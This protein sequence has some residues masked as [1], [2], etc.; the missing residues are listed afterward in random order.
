MHSV[1]R[2]PPPPPPPCPALRSPRR[3]EEQSRELREEKAGSCGRLSTSDE[4]LSRRPG[5]PWHKD[6]LVLVSFLHPRPEGSATAPWK[7]AAVL[8]HYDAIE[9]RPFLFPSLGSTDCVCFSTVGTNDVETSALHIIVGRSLPAGTDCGGGSGPGL[10]CGL[11]RASRLR[12]SVWAV[13]PGSDPS[14]VP[15]PQ[16]QA[17]C[18]LAAA[19]VSPCAPRLTP[20][21]SMPQVCPTSCSLLLCLG[22]GPCPVG[23][24]LPSPNPHA[25]DALSTW[26]IPG[27]CVLGPGAGAVCATGRRPRSTWLSPRP[28]R[29]S[30]ETRS[31]ASAAGQW[32]VDNRPFQSRATP[33]FRSRNALPGAR[34]DVFPNLFWKCP[35]NYVV[36]VTRGRPVPPGCTPSPRVLVVRLGTRSPGPVRGWRGVAPEWGPLPSAGDSLSMDVSSVHHNGALLRYSVSLLGYGFYGDIIKD[37][38]KKRWMGLVR[39]DFSGE[40]V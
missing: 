33:P 7:P 5:L 1:E 14:G 17:P 4:F 23:T 19:S 16:S 9:D 25:C 40:A 37:S 36:R 24:G 35:L 22:R 12:G 6:C 31:H 20:G 38:E 28:R 18:D 13:V 15:V 26:R 39:Y 3:A 30:R 11:P 32:H 10:A 8:N 27:T 29:I 2:H 34:Q 21:P